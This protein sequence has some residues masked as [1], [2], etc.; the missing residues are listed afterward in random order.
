LL[1]TKFCAVPPLYTQKPKFEGTISFFEFIVTFLSFLASFMHMK[2]S[3]QIKGVT[4]FHIVHTGFSL[5]YA[6]Y[7]AI[8][9]VFDGYI[10][11]CDL[12]N[13]G[14]L[15]YFLC[16][17]N[18]WDSFL[19][20][21]R[22]VTLRVGERPE[23]WKIRTCI[24]N[25]AGLIVSVLYIR[26]LMQKPCSRRAFFV[27]WGIYFGGI[28]IPISLYLFADA[29]LL[30]LRC[31]RR[32]IEAKN[33]TGITD[34]QK[35]KEIFDIGLFATLPAS[36]GIATIL[37]FV[38][39]QSS[40][41]S[42]LAQFCYFLVPSAVTL[43]LMW[44]RRYISLSHA[45]ERPSD[46]TFEWY[47]FNDS[48]SADISLA[49]TVQG[50]G[51]MAPL[52]D[53]DQ[54][55]ILSPYE[56]AEA[57]ERARAREARQLSI[58]VADIKKDL[59]LVEPLTSDV[60]VARTR[61]QPSAAAEAA[62][63]A[64]KETLPR[65]QAKQGEARGRTVFQECLSPPTSA[66]AL[67]RYFLSSIALPHL[68]RAFADHKSN[69]AALL[70]AAEP[71]EDGGGRDSIFG[72]MEHEQ[73]LQ[74]LRDEC[75]T[76]TNGFS[77][78]IT[79][80]RAQAWYLPECDGTPI[81]G[82]G[83]GGRTSFRQLA[84]P[85][86]PANQG[87]KFLFKSSA[88][89]KSKTLSHVATN[90]QVHATTVHNTATGVSKAATAITFGAPTAHSLGWKSGGL[91][92]LFLKLELCTP[93]KGFAA[94]VDLTRSQRSTKT[95]IRHLE[96]VFAAHARETVVM[97]QALAAAVAAGIDL[98]TRV[99]SNRDGKVLLQVSRIGLLLHSVCLL[100]TSGHEELMIDDFAGA[101]DRLDLTLRLGCPDCSAGGV[102]SEGGPPPGDAALLQLASVKPKP[103]A[104]HGKQSLGDLVVVL[105]VAR[106][107]FEWVLGVVGEDGVDV[108]V[109][110]V[111]FSLGVNEMQTVANAAGST[112]MQTKINQEGLRRLRAYYESFVFFE[113]QRAVHRDDSDPQLP[114]IDVYTGR[115]V[116]SSEAP[117]GTTDRAE[118]VGHV[119]SLLESLGELVE[120]EAR[121]KGKHVNM[122]L[123]ACRVARLLNGARTTSCKSAKD[124]TSIFHTLEVCRLAQDWAWLDGAQEQEVLDELRGLGGVRLRNCESNIGRAK[125][126][127]N[128]LQLQALPSELRPPASM[129]SGGR[130]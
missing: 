88:K 60:S 66:L 95:G 125:Y 82:L 130:S 45:Y 22:H 12:T 113:S 38:G 49:E 76:L 127:F 92:D 124:R 32:R 2:E 34:A 15:L 29:L 43:Y 48:P 55:A 123:Q 71:S 100:S 105:D 6:V 103:S 10:C 78:F 41:F 7:H 77:E 74:A 21:W 121:A 4:L 102:G 68:E 61:A 97:S 112:D 98:L 30:A 114:S 28:V 33:R 35:K 101:Y 5:S 16:Y 87:G 58:C 70:R 37:S 96:L 99:I 42:H 9:I 83:E 59:T 120:L 94:G 46:P 72:Q 44:K 89:K 117:V 118:L 51:L 25:L 11:D 115:R 13:L 111:L 108:Q 8:L 53:E 17:I 52:L 93:R 63:D 1:P 20:Y 67:T 91:R 24:Y 54:D 104:K 86:S 65:L 116:T 57:A 14:Y 3:G 19:R 40:L 27:F 64:S 79:F 50:D 18:M 47:S 75:R 110:P 31:Y 85:S 80:V 69:V 119:A 23:N 122:L 126:S 36:M 84:M 56:L 106:Q 62:S 128:A 81:Q 39:S 73:Q 90:L 107:D 109:V 129:A 26:A